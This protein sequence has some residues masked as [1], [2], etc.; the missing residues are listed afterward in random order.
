MTTADTH[1]GANA[2]V[3]RPWR[4]PQPTDDPELQR[5]AV[6]A[7][8]RITSTGEGGTAATTD[9]RAAMTI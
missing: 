1:H 9:V 2:H 5:Y 6:L 8:G 4:G 7:S 3:V